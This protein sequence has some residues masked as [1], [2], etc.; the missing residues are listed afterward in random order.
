MYCLFTFFPVLYFLYLLYI[1]ILNSTYFR[2]LEDV[3]NY[4]EPDLE[5]VFGLHFD[6]TRDVFGEVKVIPL[7]PNGENIP[8][9]LENK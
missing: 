2:S 1:E 9:T 8:V 4:N 3:L 7:K 5:E 6:I